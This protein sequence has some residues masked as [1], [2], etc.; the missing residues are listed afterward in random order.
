MATKIK[1]VT[2][3]IGGDA[4]GFE[5]ALRTVNN[6]IK[7][8]QSQLKDVD[9]LLKLDP[10]NTDLL[11]QK[12]VLLA[13]AIGDTKTKLDQL[14]QAQ[15]DMDANGVDKNSAQYMALQREIIQTE[16]DLG[17]L[18]AAAASCNPALESLAASADKIGGGLQAASDAIM[19][20][21]MAAAGALGG[22]GA[23][24][25]KAVT[26]ADD[27]NTMAKQTGLSTEEI[28]KMQYASD[29][30]DVSL[31]DI[32]GSMK[33]MKNNMDS[34]SSSTVAAWEKI[35]VSTR[36]ADGSMRDATEVFYEALE[37]LSKIENE[38][39]RDQV[40]MDLFGRSADNLA[41]I[42]DDGGAA[43]KA[44]GDEAEEM[45]LILSQDTLDRL[46]ET[47][48]TIDQ[49]KA[50]MGASLLE[51]GATVA[52]VLA[53]VVEQ[54]AGFI[55]G[56]AEAIRS[57]TPE[58]M[59]LIM[60]ILAVVAALGPLLAIG[61]KIFF[62]INKIL[63]TIT[64]LQGFITTTLIPA[65]GAISAPVVAVI[66]IITAL[67]AAIV[68]LYNTNEEF[69]E[70]VNAVWET[71]KQIIITVIERIQEVIQTFISVVHAAWQAWG[72]NI[73]AIAQ[74]IWS[75]IQETI[76]TAITIIQ[77]I[78]N[79]VLAVISGDWSAAWEGIKKL[80]SDIWEGIKKLVDTAI[81]AVQTV[82]SNVMEI[83][84]GIWETIWNTIKEKVSQIWEDIK[85]TVSNL[86]DTIKS[87]I[88]QVKETIT[89][90]I[91]E[92]VDYIKS[93]PGQALQWGKD[94]INNFIDGI[95]Q[96]WSD[97]VDFIKGIA[98][99]VADFIG[100]SE[101][102]K[103]PLKDFHTFAPDMVS[104]FA[105]GI[106]DNLGLITSAMDE[107]AGTVAGGTRGM[108]NVNVTSNTYLDG[109]L[110]SSTVNRELGALL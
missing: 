57:I 50:T 8:T 39:E 69:R 51:L 107:M 58:Q 104:L 68:Y 55:S 90:K 4:S 27:L 92:A 83:I 31:E 75:L 88:D 82:I 28:Q 67:V 52:E 3:E 102:E 13:N 10:G 110:I 14:K 25:Y 9:K 95:K 64:A 60:T 94:M 24:G 59:Q 70:K 61:A 66:A 98:D 43:L 73:L 22:L 23:L 93:L 86:L 103:G 76:Q 91:G 96:A 45:G 54:V 32:T 84:K 40:A 1:G 49:M 74:D 79:I 87:N 65:I 105:S 53:P 26:T 99:D 85:T 18:Q 106:R 44:Y 109:R 48:D 15:A 5:K 30:V 38:T 72:N 89:T 46:N 35:G 33:K 108:A 29:R 41:G 37:G 63:T 11:K 100:F 81:N 97:G 16:Q 2:I 62:G 17:K 78:L 77:D 42:I 19:P 56:I 80:A 101:P 20:F 34:T 47:N 12:Q 36:N 6:S 21:S 7:Q 71:V